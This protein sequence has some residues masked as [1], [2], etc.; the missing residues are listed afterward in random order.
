VV[1]ARRT[2]NPRW[3]VGPPSAGSMSNAHGVRHSSVD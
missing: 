1:A 3:S 2:T